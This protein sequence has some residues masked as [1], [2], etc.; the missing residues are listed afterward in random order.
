MNMVLDELRQLSQR[1]PP[2][3]FEARAVL[4]R[5]QPHACA[6]AQPN[7]EQTIRGLR[8]ATKAQPHQQATMLRVRCQPASMQRAASPSSGSNRPWRVPAQDAMLQ[9]GTWHWSEE[10]SIM[11]EVTEGSLWHRLPARPPAGTR[12]RRLAKAPSSAC[13]TISS[14]ACGWRSSSTATSSALT[15]PPWRTTFAAGSVR[16]L[17]CSRACAAR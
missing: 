12:S 11:S 2:G 6:R 13:W 1:F 16:C 9:L 5:V 10:L 3:R 8:S 14:L 17:P 7:L 4:A 15:P